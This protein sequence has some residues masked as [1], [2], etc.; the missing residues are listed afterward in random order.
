LHFLCIELWIDEPVCCCIVE[1]P[2]ILQQTDPKPK[3]IVVKAVAKSVPKTKLQQIKPVRPERTKSTRV[4]TG[5]VRNGKKINRGRNNGRMGRP[6]KEIGEFDDILS[7]GRKRAAKLYRIEQGQICEWAWREY[8]GGGVEP[9]TGCSG[10]AARHIH[11]G[12]DKSTFNNDRDS[13]ISIICTFCHQL[14]HARNDK[15]YEGERPQDGSEWVP[16]SNGG[17]MEIAGLDESRPTSIAEIIA[18]ELSIGREMTV[19]DWERIR[20]ERESTG[21]IIEGAKG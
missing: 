20:S 7:S 18:F 6:E 10:R 21:E 13:N 3:A 4:L 15:Y 11:H 5:T 2:T 14:W 12:P 16:S 19:E 8:N 1:Q 17:R 9:V